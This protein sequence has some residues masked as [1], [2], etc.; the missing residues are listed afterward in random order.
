MCDILV[1]AHLLLYKASVSDSLWFFPL[2]G[3][4]DTVE[5]ERDRS[6]CSTERERERERESVCVCVCVR[7]RAVIQKCASKFPD[8]SEQWYSLTIS[9][10]FSSIRFH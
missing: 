3:K 8:L 10:K 2:A 5:N 4:S 6:M 9:I 1:V 7:V